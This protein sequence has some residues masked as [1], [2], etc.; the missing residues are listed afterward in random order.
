MSEIDRRYGNANFTNGMQDDIHGQSIADKHPL[1][2]KIIRE[3]D[4]LDAA[5]KF[6]AML[7]DERLQANYFRI[8]ALVHLAV[9]NATGKNVLTPQQIE[10]CFA[11]RDS[12]PFNRLTDSDRHRRRRIEGRSS[13]IFCHCNFEVLESNTIDAP[14][15]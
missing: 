12:A 10:Y 8:E 4:R 11:P 15:I 7:L 2:M 1:V 9:D 3:A 13:L 14:P 5:S 6:G